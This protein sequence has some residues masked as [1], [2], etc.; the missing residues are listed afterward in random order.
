MLI[1]FMLRLYNDQSRPSMTVRSVGGSKHIR[2]KALEK[3]YVVLGSAGAGGQGGVSFAKDRSDPPQDRVVKYYD[4][5]EA[6]IPLDMIMIGFQTLTKLDHPNIARVYEAFEDPYGSWIYVVSEPYFGGDLT[7][8][9][10]KAAEAGVTVDVQWL[11]CIFKQV[12]DGLGYLHGKRVMHCDLKEPNAMV[13]AINDWQSPSIV[14]IDFDM[15]QHFGGGRQAGGTPGYMPPEVWEQGLW[16][17]KGDVFCFGVMIYHLVADRRAFEGM[18]IERIKAITLFCMPDLNVFAHAP[19]VADVVQRTLARDFRLRPMVG[20]LQKMPLFTMVREVERR[21][22]KKSATHKLDEL[23]Q[24]AQQPRSDIQGILMKD[25]VG[26]LNLAEENE[27]N[28]LFR[29]LDLDG[30]GVITTEELRA[31][32]MTANLAPPVV[33][34]LIQNM[35]KDGKISYADFMAQMMMRCSKDDDDHIRRI[36]MGADED[37]NG[38]LT[39]EEVL[40]LLQRPTVCKECKLAPNELI[41]NFDVDANGLIDFQEFKRVMLGHPRAATPFKVGDTVE[42]HSQSIRQWLPC[43][44]TSVRDDNIMISM[45]PGLWCGPKQAATCIRKQDPY[46]YFSS[47]HGGWLPCQ[48]IARNVETGT[49]MLD[50][51]RGQWLSEDMIRGKLVNDSNELPSWLFQCSGVDPKLP[52]RVGELVHVYSNSGKVWIQNA[53]VTSVN[54]DGINVVYPDGGTKMIPLSLLSDCNV[55][56]RAVDVTPGANPLGSA[57]PFGAPTVPPGTNPTRSTN[58][59]D[60][61]RPRPV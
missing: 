48:I 16:T 46:R 29:G 52:M 23:I 4:R 45:K 44:V 13:K 34:R 51:K 25:L 36:F 54:F 22:F 10:A 18:T 1:E 58:P 47:S 5:Q 27:L 3:D 55:I 59:F 50:V 26:R 20:A 37:G 57:N 8:V 19:L 40:A 28:A 2:K 39:R 14:L 33:E 43:K 15:V 30:N 17:P 31:G 6:S 24:L 49:I 21:A 32:L 60:V 12:L 53:K 9:K 61:P 56:V 7:K 11:A 42:Y 41:K 38:V 35:G